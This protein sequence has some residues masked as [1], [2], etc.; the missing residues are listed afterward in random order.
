MI[1]VFFTSIRIEIT[2]LVTKGDV[3]TIFLFS[4]IKKYNLMLTDYQN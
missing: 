2:G 1:S 3:N 4:Q